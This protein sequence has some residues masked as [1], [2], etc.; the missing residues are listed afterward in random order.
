MSSRSTSNALRGPAAVAHRAARAAHAA[1][2]RQAP[3]HGARLLDI[4]PTL[5]EAAGHEIPESFQG[6]SLFGG[7]LRQSESG[8]FGSAEVFGPA[9]NLFER[10]IWALVDRIVDIFGVMWLRRRYKPGLYNL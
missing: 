7:S 2:A 8:G 4:A 1:A 3:G 6:R 9:T 10:F 5:M